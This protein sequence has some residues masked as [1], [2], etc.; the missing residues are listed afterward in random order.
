[1]HR[2]NTM[3]RRLRVNYA[4]NQAYSSSQR[5]STLLYVI[6]GLVILAAV[7]AGVSKLTPTSAIT[8]ISG[9]RGHSAYYAA[10]SGVNYIQERQKYYQDNS[11]FAQFITDM[12]ATPTLTLSNGETIALTITD[13]SAT[14]PNTFSYDIVGALNS[15]ASNE[16]SYRLTSNDFGGD[17][18]FTP[19]GG[20]SGTGG[21]GLFLSGGRFT[22]QQHSTITGD[23]QADG[24][25][26]ERQ[27][28]INGNITSD[29][30]ATVQ[31][32]AKII[33]DICV[34][35]NLQVEQNAKITGNIHATGYVQIQQ[36]TEIYGN[37]YS[38]RRV[39]WEKNV[40]ISGKVFYGTSYSGDETLVHG[41]PPEKYAEEITCKLTNIPDPTFPSGS[42]PSLNVSQGQ[43]CDFKSGDTFLNSLN[44]EHHANLRFD[45]S[46]GNPIRVY[47][48]YGFNFQHHLEV[49][50]KFVDGGEY[51]RMDASDPRFEEAAAKIL[52]ETPGGVSVEQDSD[53]LGT[54]FAKYDINIQTKSNILGSFISKEGSI[55]TK[56]WSIIKYVPFGYEF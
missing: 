41:G 26:I 25:T 33:G 11:T 20:G 51:V 35:G 43:N 31:R 7:S 12:Q 10:L 13:E 50:V 40:L 17:Q 54:I 32:W 37:I 4:R 46:D 23:I 5:G 42:Y 22:G 9:A 14:A 15:G 2:I 53:W 34:Y 39:S 21:E 30:D 38:N 45:L 24:V 49:Y 52:F 44:V 48:K 29:G 56:Q 27:G 1:M 16:A 19:S 47:V 36:N 28:T 55:N 8:E 18:T 3:A 6:A